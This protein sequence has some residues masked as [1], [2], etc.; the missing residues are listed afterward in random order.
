VRVEVEASRRRRA[1]R[2]LPRRPVW[3]PVLVLDDEARSAGTT[4]E[5][6]MVPPLWLNGR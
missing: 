6:C 4:A 5:T 2:R 1:R 3:V